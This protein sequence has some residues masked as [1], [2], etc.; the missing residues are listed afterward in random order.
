MDEMTNAASAA[1]S[2]AAVAAV[3]ANAAI[4]K[5]LSDI[6]VSQ[7]KNDT[8]IKNIGLTVIEIKGDV[9]D[10]KQLYVTHAEF[11]TYRK[12]VDAVQKDHESRIR[13]SEMWYRYGIAAVVII[14]AIIGWYLII[15]YNN[16]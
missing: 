14:N 4:M 5:E 2:A 10:I 8:E 15:H 3:T 16:H 1:A 13:T 11:A 7:G 6:K 9:K 12:E